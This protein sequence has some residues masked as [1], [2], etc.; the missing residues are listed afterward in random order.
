MLLGSSFFQ[1]HASDC[2][3]FCGSL[4]TSARLFN[5]LLNCS[6][7]IF[8]PILRLYLFWGSGWSKRVSILPNN[9][10]WF[11]MKIVW[12]LFH[13]SFCFLSWFSLI[14]TFIFYPGCL[15][16]GVRCYCSLSINS[17]W[18]GLDGAPS[19]MSAVV[20]EKSWSKYEIKWSVAIMY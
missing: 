7:I 2:S 10:F 5:H 6:Q 14:A 16:F 1:P 17:A 4:S 3:S 13:V 9:S 12:L 18:V 19:I 15:S 20:L 8:R 11:W